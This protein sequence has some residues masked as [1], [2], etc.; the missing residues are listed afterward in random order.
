MLTSPA[1]G[2]SP[3]CSVRRRS[4]R[5]RCTSRHPVSHHLLHRPVFPSSPPP[6][7]LSSLLPVS[8]VN[9]RS[10]HRPNKTT[11]REGDPGQYWPLS[12]AGRVS[13][14]LLGHLAHHPETQRVT[15]LQPSPASCLP[16]ALP[17]YHGP[18]KQLLS[19]QELRGSGR[20]PC[21]PTHRSYTTCTPITTS[22]IEVLRTHGIVTV[23]DR[24]AVYRF[25]SFSVPQR[26]SWASANGSRI[27]VTPSSPPPTRRARTPSL[28]RSLSTPRLSSPPR[29][30]TLPRETIGGSLYYW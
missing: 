19:K 2:Q 27:K 12:A 16:S 14:A 6:P 11:T 5:Q 25:L 24:I 15:N 1:T 7:T 28:T 17:R 13:I 20:G 8:H 21:R 29:K 22:S 4:A 23:T 10:Y 30:I 3:S 26:M 18:S 9:A